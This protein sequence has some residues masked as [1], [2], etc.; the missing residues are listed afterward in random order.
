[1]ALSKCPL[2]EISPVDSPNGVVAGPRNKLFNIADS[3]AKPTEIEPEISPIAPMPFRFE[4]SWR[5]LNQRSA[6]SGE[7]VP[8]S[9]HS[10]CYPPTRVD[11]G[12]DAELRVRDAVL[13]FMK[14]RATAP[15]ALQ[16]MVSS[17][18]DPN[19]LTTAN[20]GPQN[21]YFAVV[22]LFLLITL[23]FGAMRT[24]TNQSALASGSA[25]DSV[26]MSGTGWMSEWV[27]DS[28][29]SALGRQIS[30]YRPS[31]RMSDYR[32]EFVGGIER[33]SLG[34]A[35]RV[36]D[37][38]NYQVAKLQRS[39]QGV[40]LELIRFAVVRG[41]EG[42]H[43]Q[44]TLPLGIG[45]GVIRVRLDA[46]GSLFTI[47]VQNHVVE[48]WVDDRLKTGGVGFLN[49]RGEQGQVKSVQ[50]SFRNGTGRQ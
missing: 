18:T 17:Q 22:V 24:A 43:A 50:I 30:L 40:P 15:P 12:C 4:V 26:E 37:S 25:T 3:P 29:G 49:E 6:I 20:R 11:L 5:S 27:S 21:R 10:V 2:G 35:F 31:S 8:A 9:S 38:K 1:M 34:W 42:R 19:F 47:S 23:A 39:T 14:P 7:A 16:S 45:V 44:T 36:V 28:T 13:S 41:V 33:K 32:L 46:I 48:E